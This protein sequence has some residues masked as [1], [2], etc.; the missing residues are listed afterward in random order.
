VH[1]ACAVTLRFVSP[2]SASAV[3][4]FV[5]PAVGWSTR[6]DAG[7]DSCDCACG[8]GSGTTNDW[9]DWAL[10]DDLGMLCCGSR[11]LPANMIPKIRCSVITSTERSAGR[12]GSQ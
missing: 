10:L 9:F 5:G 11:T 12:S 6:A 8:C 3:V 2:P 4:A 1:A 7:R